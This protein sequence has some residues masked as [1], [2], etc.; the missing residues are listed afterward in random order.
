[1]LFSKILKKFLSFHRKP[2][3]L[4]FC[5]E[6]KL[7][8]V[9]KVD[10][11]G[12]EQERKICRFSGDAQIDEFIDDISLFFRESPISYVDIGAYIGEIPQKIIESGKI[13]IRSACLIEPN[14]KSFVKIKNLK[15]AYGVEKFVAKNVG[16]SFERGLAVFR[17]NA[18]MTKRVKSGSEG[19][20][21]DIFEVECRALDD[22]LVSFGEERINLLKIDVEG[23]ELDVLKSAEQALSRQTFDVIYIEVGFNKHGTQQTYFSDIDRVLQR[24]D[25]RVFRIYEQK[26]EWI[27]DSPLLRRCNF[28]YMSQRFA[29]SHL[30]SEVVETGARARMNS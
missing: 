2:A 13:R 25:Y 3:T 21:A 10:K 14:P 7:N 23:E 4:D 1:M 8:Y 30:Y 15:E 19:D 12:S 20:R 6:K 22:I 16:I 9:E 18:T 26:N 5:V 29:A 11:V 17:D 24:F 27:D 28:A